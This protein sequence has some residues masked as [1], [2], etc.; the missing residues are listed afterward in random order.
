[1]LEKMI[2]EHCAPTL[3]GLKMAG[4]FGYKIENELE[5]KKSI[6]SV[7]EILNG[8]GVFV[9][10]IN[11]DS[12]RVLVY[13]YR[14]QKLNNYLNSKEVKDFLHNYGYDEMDIDVCLR[15]LKARV[16][17]CGSFPHEIGIF[18]GYPLDDVQGFI[19]HRGCNY[20]MCGIWKVYGDVISASK[21]FDLYRKCKRAYNVQLSSGKDISQLTVFA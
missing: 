10:V 21:K 15:T 4:V 20:K 3:A 9:D 12:D 19:Q 2:V 16:S 14:K 18:L 5:F 17:E 8:K 7:N 11:R 13:V 6:L 1:M